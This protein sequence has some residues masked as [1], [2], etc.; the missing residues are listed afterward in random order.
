MQNPAAWYIFSVKPEFTL[1]L[2]R[3]SA[4]STMVRAQVRTR[5][6]LQKQYSQSARNCSVPKDDIHGKDDLT[7]QG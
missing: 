6:G 7:R 2:L 3:T 4:Y 1:H 5:S